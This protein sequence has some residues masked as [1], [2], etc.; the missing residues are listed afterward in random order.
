ME[1][2]LDVR[3]LLSL[4]APFV[5]LLT[6]LFLEGAIRSKELLRRLH[7]ARTIEA[8]A[9]LARGLPALLGLALSFRLLGEALP[10]RHLGEIAGRVYSALLV[11]GLGLLAL[12]ITALAVKASSARLGLPSAQLS[13]VENLSRASVGV[14]FSLAA[15]QTLG[16][17]VAP[18]L[19]ALGVGGLAAALALQSTL[20]N[21]VA[22]LQL[23]ASGQIRRGDRLRLEDGSEGI[24]EDVGW[25]STSIRLPSG[26]L[27][28][29]PNSRMTSMLLV[30]RARGPGETISVQI[31]LDA[32]WDPDEIEELGLKASR[33]AARRLELPWARPRATLVA[34]DGGSLRLRVALEVEGGLDRETIE[35]ELTKELLKAIRR[36]A[37]GR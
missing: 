16:V 24:V 19:T 20:S 23:I 37:K 28:L 36:E 1:T 8:M 34:G 21:A 15:L 6:G 32:G 25:R 2:E 3:R 5:P 12:R 26:D 17:P 7:G 35:H 30:L 13:I 10:W 33:E 27:M 18:M 31:P 14:V 9:E 22:G 11:L 4:L 29:V